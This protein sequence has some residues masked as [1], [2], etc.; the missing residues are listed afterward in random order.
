LDKLLWKILKNSLDK[1]IKSSKC[2]LSPKIVQ[3]FKQKAKNTK[4]KNT[5]SKKIVKKSKKSKN[6]KTF[7][8]ITNTKNQKLKQN[9]YQTNTKSLYKSEYYLA[10]SLLKKYSNL[11]RFF[12]F[13]NFILF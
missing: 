8:K 2:S 10:K 9:S 13:P 11:W 4:S 6:K 12:Y 3:K 5:K 1:K 7:F